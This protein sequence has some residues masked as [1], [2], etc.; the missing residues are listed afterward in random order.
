M[1]TSGREI[2]ARGIDGACWTSK[3]AINMKE[4]RDKKNSTAKS[5]HGDIAYLWRGLVGIGGFLKWVQEDN[6]Y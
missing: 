4:T 6:G 1:D 5:A 2:K 3:M